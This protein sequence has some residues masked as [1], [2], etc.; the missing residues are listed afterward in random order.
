MTGQRW[1]RTAGQPGVTS[2]ATRAAAWLWW[3]FCWGW[4][5]ATRWVPWRWDRLR[6]QLSVTWWEMALRWDRWRG[7]RLHQRMWR[8]HQ[9]TGQLYVTDR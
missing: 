1:S 7:H 5:A 9:R 8:H 4:W 6:Y 3:G 2:A